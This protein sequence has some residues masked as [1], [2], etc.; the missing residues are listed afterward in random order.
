MLPPARGGRAFGQDHQ[1]RLVHRRAARHPAAQARPR[2]TRARGPAAVAPRPAGRAACRAGAT[3][4]ASPAGIRT[5]SS[6]TLKRPSAACAPRRAPAQRDPARRRDPAHGRLVVRRGLHVLAARTPA[7]N[8]RPS[9]YTSPTS[10]SSAQQALHD[11]G[12]EL[13]PF[14]LGEDARHG[15]EREPPSGAPEAHAGRWQAALHLG[16]HAAGSASA[17]SSAA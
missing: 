10:A 6:I 14:R 1:P 13:G 3:E 5:W 4:Y 9:P 11:A 12:L 2:R 16:G 8:T 7:S 17:S 15:V